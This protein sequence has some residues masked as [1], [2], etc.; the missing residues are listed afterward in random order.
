M[1]TEARDVKGWANELDGV[2]ERLG[3]HFGRSEPRQRVMTYMRGLM[4][5][6][7]RKNGWQLAEEAGDDTPYGVQHLLGRATWNADSVRDDLRGYVLAHLGDTDGVLVVDETGFLKKGTKSVGVSRQYSGT[8]GRIENCQIGVFVA[9]A[10]RHGRALIDRELYLPHEWT[11]DRARCDEAGVPAKRGFATK[12]RLALEMLERAYQAGIQAKWV[13][14][15][16]VY[17]SDSKFRRALEARNQGFVVAVT[18][19]Q[20]LWIGF[21]QRMVREIAAEAPSKAWQ[22]MSAGVGAKGSR[23]Y[24]WFVYP[25]PAFNTPEPEVFGRWLLV[26]RNIS[27]STELAYY[28]CGGLPDTTL[29]ELVRVAG[30]RWVIEDCFEA[31]KGEVGLDQYEVRSWQGWYRHI[32]LA[33]FALAVLAVIR[34]KAIPPPSQASPSK[35]TH[36]VTPSRSSH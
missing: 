3:W 20:R 5:T 34:M 7:E 13:T 21:Q 8:A 2:S 30:M 33:M 25:F 6:V 35:K 15:D 16:E 36:V 12:L 11:D 26:R 4:S 10:S 27:D 32:T 9:Y 22:R 23:L 24:D 29:E 17:G 18:S 31:A 14:A 28:L 1:Q 19:Q